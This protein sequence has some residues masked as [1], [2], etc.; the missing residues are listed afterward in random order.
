MRI[1]IRSGEREFTVNC[2][3][4]EDLLTVLQSAGLH[5]PAGCGGRGV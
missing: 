3:A 5:V 4:G 1:T 2:A